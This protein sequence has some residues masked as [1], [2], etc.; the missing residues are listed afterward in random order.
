MH[1][2]LTM[3]FNI[4]YS[5]LQIYEL[6]ILASTYNV[7][8]PGSASYLYELDYTDWYFGLLLAY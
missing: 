6:R 3:L 2:P 8:L 4:Q 7:C 5:N 1:Y